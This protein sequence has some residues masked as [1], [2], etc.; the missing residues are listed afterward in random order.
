MHKR[1]PSRWASVWLGKYSCREYIQS[2]YCRG[3]DTASLRRPHL[4]WNVTFES[5]DARDDAVKSRRASPAG[6][7]SEYKETY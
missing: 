7:T 1:P 6:D 2:C 4:P 5:G 3:R